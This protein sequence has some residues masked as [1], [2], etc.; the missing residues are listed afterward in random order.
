VTYFSLDCL[1]LPDTAPI[2]LVCAAGEAGYDSFSLWVQPPAMYEVMLATPAMAKE[3]AAAMSD[4]GV[5]LG[6]LE[7]FNLNSD[8]PIDAFEPAIAFGAALGGRTATAIDFGAPRA[9]IADRFASFHAL[10]AR[11]GVATLVEP[12]SMGNVRTPQDGL[13]LI[14]EAGVDARLVIDCAHLVRTGCTAETLRSIPRARIGHLQLCDGPPSVTP[15]QALIEASADRLYPG[16]GV[17]PL[18]EILAAIR[19]DVPVGLE[20]PNLAR[21]QRGLSAVDRAREAISSARAV[22]HQV[23][24][25]GR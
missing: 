12:I 23:G 18:V 22:L 7:V 16:E 2:D 9:D 24:G 17:F 20:V 25:R 14:E 4:H 3:L 6:N 11:H 5:V 19:D 13:G 10:C 15:E 21:L 1:T 8:D